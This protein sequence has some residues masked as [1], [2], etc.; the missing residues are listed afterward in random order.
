M[1]S[2]VVDYEVR[3]AVATI[4]LNRPE[5]R[6]SLGGTMREDIA[7]AF[8]RAS[9]DDDVRVIVLTGVGTVFCA[10][11]DLKELV[12]NMGADR[13]LSERLTPRRDR[14]LLSVYEASKPVIAA[15]NGPALGA[16]MN[17]A[18]AADIRIASTEAK[19]A[20]SFVKRGNVPDYGGTYLLPRIVGLSKAY[21]LVYTGRM[22]DAHEALRI[23][24]VSAVKPAGDLMSAALA[25][26]QEIVGN[27][28]L[29]VRLS[30]R[31]MQAN[32]GDL[33][34]A[35]ERETAAQN[36]CFESEDN[37]EG[38]LSFLEGRSPTFSGR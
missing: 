17:L 29:A 20:Q 27:A 30:K 13:P 35:L 26:A 8:V 6:N 4:S 18:L 31:V 14:A 7:D 21:E 22:I 23:Q 34:G 9:T 2:R 16:G 38:F 11:G 10:G 1:N 25:L 12:E 5:R 36:I 33:R 3:D 32:L 37:R 15:I 19:F 28:P 24:L